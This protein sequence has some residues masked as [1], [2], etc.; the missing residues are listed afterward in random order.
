MSGVNYQRKR[1][2]KD[3]D[4][5]EIQA[6]IG[7]LYLSVVFKSNKLNIEDIWTQSTEWYWRWRGA[8]SFD[9]VPI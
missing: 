3:T 2:A 1:D 6:V 7:L 8:I 4:I 5:L 9:D